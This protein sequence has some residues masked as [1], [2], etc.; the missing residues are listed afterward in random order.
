MMALNGSRKG[1]GFCG[2]LTIVF[3]AMK[4]LDKIACSWWW[5]LS[6]LW[7]PAAIIVAIVLIVLVVC[8][9]IRGLADISRYLRRRKGKDV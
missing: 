9:A 6:P 5:V 4:L 2:L 8:L 3:V 7:M 1:V